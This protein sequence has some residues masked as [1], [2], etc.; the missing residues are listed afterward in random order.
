MIFSHVT[1]ILISR[2]L[3]GQGEDQLVLNANQLTKPYL[4]NEDQEIMVSK[5]LKE[6][7]NEDDKHELFKKIFGNN[8]QMAAT[9]SQVLKR[10]FLSNSKLFTNKP[11]GLKPVVGDVVAILKEDPRL[12]LIV[13][14]LSDH[15]VIVRHKHRGSNV[16]L[17]YHSKILA[18]VFRPISAAFFVSILEQPS[19][20]M[21]HLL[22]R[23]WA[24]LKDQMT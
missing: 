6:V 10:E 21:N 9:A 16:E 20:V 13:D 22:E 2:P 3:S 12:G 4:S 19:L 18:L 24:K 23:F 5:F 14:V 8:H 15:R 17:T 11:A 1:N 7:F